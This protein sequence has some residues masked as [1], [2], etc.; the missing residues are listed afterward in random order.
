M[1]ST[2]QSILISYGVSHAD[3]GTHR[4]MK[5]VARDGEARQFV[6]IGPTGRAIVG[7]R[8]ADRI[9]CDVGAG[10]NGDLWH[11]TPTAVFAAAGRAGIDIDPGILWRCGSWMQLTANQC[12]LIT[13][14]GSDAHATLLGD[15]VFI[16]PDLVYGSEHA[17]VWTWCIS[18]R[19]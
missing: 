4:V 5:M 16:W 13:S 12:A 8:A 15:E 7:R 11:R 17:T 3:G 14:S 1:R 10:E 2:H 18:G 9:H 19:E 6:M